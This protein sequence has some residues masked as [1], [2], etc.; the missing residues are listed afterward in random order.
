MFIL[1]NIT[2]L[3][4]CFSPLGLSLLIIMLNSELF[5]LN[6]KDKIPVTY[7]HI[8]ALKFSNAVQCIYQDSKGFMWFGTWNGLYKYDGYKLT[9]YKHD[10]DN[11]NTISDDV[12]VA[13]HEDKHPIES[14]KK[15]LWVGTRYGGLNRFDLIQESWTHF[16]HHPTDTTSVS[17]NTILSILEDSWGTLWIGTGGGG[18]N[19][20]DREN[21]KFSRFGNR[22]DLNSDVIICMCEEQQAAQESKGN[23]WLGTDRGLV[24]F[25]PGND[26]FIPYPCNSDQYQ[27]Y[28][29]GPVKAV[30]EDKKGQL[31]IGMRNGALFQF[32]RKNEKFSL[33]PHNPVNTNLK[34]RKKILSLYEDEQGFLWVGTDKGLYLIKKESDKTLTHY[35]LTHNPEINSGLN[36]NI[37]LSLFKDKTDVVWIGTVAGINKIDL[38]RKP[39]KTYQKNFSGSEGINHNYVKTI[40]NDRNGDLWIGTWGGGVNFFNRKTNRW[41]YFLDDTPEPYRLSSN[42]I[43]T[44]YEDSKGNIWIGTDN[45]LD[46][47]NRRNNTVFHFYHDPNDPNCLGHNSVYSI[48]EDKFGF[49]WIG[50]FTGVLNRYDPVNNSFNHF[51]YSAQ[52]STS[53][54]KCHGVFAIKEDSYGR[55]WF[56]TAGGGLV[57]L[58]SEGTGKIRFKTF[59]HLSGDIS[60]LLSNTVYSIY[61]SKDSK[62]WIGTKKGFSRIMPGDDKDVDFINYKQ[63]DGYI[64]MSILED[65]RGNLWMSGSKGILKFNPHTRL[66]KQY[67]QSDGITAG[68]FFWGAGSKNE[69]NSELMFGGTKGLL[70]FTADQIKENTHIPPVALTSLKISNQ[71]ISIHKHVSL[72]TGKNSTDYWGQN[73]QILSESITYAQEI[74]LSP[75]QNH[76]SFQFA[77]LDYSCPEKN[78]YAYKMER[79]DEDWIH[80]GNQREATF[81]NLDPGTYTFRVKGS[82][83]DGVWNE[84]GASL[85]IIILPPWWATW[86]FRGILFLFFVALVL[87]AHRL[88]VRHMRRDQQRQ[89]E[90]SRR[91]IESQ[92]AERKRI[93]SGLHDSLGQNLL[94]VNNEIQQLVL[95]NEQ[96]EEKVK[97][98]LSGVKESINEVREISQNLHPHLLDRLG[99]NKALE[100]V[101]KKVSKSSGIRIEYE[102]DEVEKF[103]DKEKQIHF[104]RIIQEALNNIVKHARADK[105]E[106]KIEKKRKYLY[107]IVRDNGKGFD[108]KKVKAANHSK[109]G[110]GLANM[111]E[112]ARLI[113]GKFHISSNPKEG[114]RIELKMPLSF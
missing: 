19:R 15:Y 63:E 61:Q 51:K 32:D 43:H 76:I 74:V 35:L 106:I 1:N 27:T 68:N 6:D 83:N 73:N 85:K 23:I 80:I 102:L 7:Q 110:L 99:L 24:K 39:F 113:G 107:T 31:W 64:V 18:L 9:A 112:R 71:E 89:Q 60:S 75:Q 55:L 62:L 30:Y 69:T 26:R 88:R 54:P 72:K 37:I 108:I 25:D 93:A 77:A 111:Q 70:T 78:Q 3:K 98:I 105:V 101:I 97:P 109:I 16:K 94:I 14:N 52:D 96:M 100:S 11:P 34:K 50:T 87:T 103:F 22:P 59:K 95:E 104:Y 21:G 12:I 57:L 10:P 46:K 20:M 5:A 81:T 114:T 8:E 40:L 13:I 79:F 29:K 56:G 36:S 42:N 49:F 45:G 47:L 86:W 65:A 91:L 67:D 90:F 58:D 84:Q 17:N 41:S 33:D 48:C 82:N 53:F 2:K 66:F 28:A 38:K 92:E 4:R 44:L